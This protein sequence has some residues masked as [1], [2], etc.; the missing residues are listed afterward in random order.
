M[1]FDKV[2][3][4]TPPDQVLKLLGDP[5]EA[6][7]KRF[8]AWRANIATTIIHT[9]VGF[10]RRF[11]SVHYTEFDVFEKAEGDAGYNA[12]L[13]RLCG[14]T[15]AAPHYNLAY[16]LTEWVDPNQIIQTQQHHTPLYTVDAMRYRNEV[17]ATNGENHTYHAGAYLGNGLHEGAISSGLVVSRLLG[18]EEL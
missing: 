10:Y 15:D 2:I 14:L 12:F 17:I 13:N 7:R 8:G 9:D 1:Q 4:A 16:N 5:S 3:F 18:G 11:K 6:E